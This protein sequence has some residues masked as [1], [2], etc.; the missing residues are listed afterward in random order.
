[1][2]VQYY[3]I[4]VG[5]DENITSIQGRAI[6]S[7]TYEAFCQANGSLLRTIYAAVDEAGD[8]SIATVLGYHRPNTQQQKLTAFDG[9]ITLKDGLL[10]FA[11]K[12]AFTTGVSAVKHDM[13][14][15]TD[16]NEHEDTRLHYRQSTDFTCGPVAVLDAMRIR[17]LIAETTRKLE[18]EIW[19]E[20]TIALACDPY[21][22]A[23]AADKR[24]AHVEVFVSREGPVLHP[25]SGLGI[26]NAELAQYTQTEFEREVSN[27]GIPVHLGPISAQTVAQQLKLGKIVVL[28]IDEF[29]MHGE[30]CPHWITVTAYRESD[31]IFVVDDPWTD[32]IFGETSVDAYQIPIRFEDLESMMHYDEPRSAQALL[33][34]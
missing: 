15:D 23:L 16:E 9:D 17:G 21:G 33:V 11:Q 5:H 24:S 4:P 32:E 22:L 19:R 14:A 29:D 28:L 12:H 1:M 25:E 3:A 34:L 6:P 18:L 26:M 7:V 20:A 27:R 2:S 31:N 8:S 10:R 13:S 30:T